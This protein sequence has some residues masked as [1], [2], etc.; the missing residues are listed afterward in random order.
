[1]CE[2]NFHL[3]NIDSE[4]ENYVENDV[5]KTRIREL[6]LANFI[7]DKCGLMNKIKIIFE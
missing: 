3:I 1:M 4:N 6:R 5:C 2:H 7:C